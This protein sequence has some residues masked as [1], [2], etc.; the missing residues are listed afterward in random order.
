M[1]LRNLVDAIKRI[2]IHTKIR[3]HFPI[4]GTARNPPDMRARATSYCHL[5]FQQIEA[6]KEALIHSSGVLRNFY[7][8]K[9]GLQMLQRRENAGTI[10]ALQGLK[11][12][13]QKLIQIQKK[14]NCIYGELMLCI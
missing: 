2:S 9:R 3:R 4:P 10:M 14:E 11:L 1:R 6:L 5:L 13:L 12:S 8:T 7:M